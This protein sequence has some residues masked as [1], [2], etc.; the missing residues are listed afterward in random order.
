MLKHVTT[1]FLFVILAVAQG[2]FAQSVHGPAPE[3]ATSAPPT[4]DA[5]LIPEPGGFTR[6]LEYGLRR[7]GVDAGEKDGF[8]PEFGNMITGSGW[9]SLGPGYR[10]H[11]LGGRG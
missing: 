4:Q 11:F 9:L 6:T 10:Q 7:F 2:T 5:G 8:Y 1:A 3:D